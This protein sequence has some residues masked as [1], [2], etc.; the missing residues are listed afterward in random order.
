MLEERIQQGVLTAPITG[1]VVSKD[2]KQQIG[3]PVKTGTV[4]FEVAAV[5]ALR[6]ELYV[7]ED[8][9]SDIQNDQTGDLMAVG[10]PNQ[11]IAFV[12]ERISPVADVVNQRN[13]FRVRVRLEKRHEWMR[14]GME[15]LAKITVGKASYAWLASR[16]VI[17][18][19]RMVLWI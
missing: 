5:N 17:N 12:V 16:R 4:L 18:W 3:A 1:L 13:I 10:H 2:L 9:I 7:P 14:P 11:K 15:G 6:A 8:N 19:L